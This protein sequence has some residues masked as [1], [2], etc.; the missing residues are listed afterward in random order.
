MVFCYIYKY[1]T[2][3]KIAIFSFCFVAHIT[4]QIVVSL[5]MSIR[6]Q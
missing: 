6:K 3:F 5:P 2:I 1:A 4:N